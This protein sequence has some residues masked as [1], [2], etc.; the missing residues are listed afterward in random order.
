MISAPLLRIPKHYFLITKYLVIIK[1]MIYYVL[2]LGK[3][4]TTTYVKVNFNKCY[5]MHKLVLR[6]SGF[7]KPN[8]KQKHF[9]VKKIW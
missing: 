8:Y 7:P 6:L 3:R 5:E 9:L 1:Y 2:T 4:F